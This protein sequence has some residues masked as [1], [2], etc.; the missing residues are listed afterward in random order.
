MKRDLEDQLLAF[1]L[2]QKEHFRLSQWLEL[3]VPSDAKA[4]VALY[5]ANATWYGHR[6]QLFDIAERMHPGSVGHFSE[7]AR[8]T[9]FD[10]SRF[11][12]RLEAMFAHEQGV[13]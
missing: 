8:L 9:D 10:P 11:R 2:H 1:C 12:G 13:S 3:P 7:L 4:T 6:L 5:L